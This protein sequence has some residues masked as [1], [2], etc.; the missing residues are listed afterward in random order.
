MGLIR[1]LTF[2]TQEDSVKPVETYTEVSLNDEPK[3]SMMG[4]EKRITDIDLKID[5]MF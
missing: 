3:P 5:S 2:I 1:L 4:V